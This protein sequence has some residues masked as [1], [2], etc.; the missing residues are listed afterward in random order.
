VSGN[1]L[2]DDA[3][4][5]RPPP[6]V[7]LRPKELTIAHV[8]VRNARQLQKK[9]V[10]GYLAHLATQPAN[11][12]QASHWRELYAQ[13]RDGPEMS[14]SR[15]RE[16][17]FNYGLPRDK[18]QPPDMVALV[19]DPVRID[20]EQRYAASAAPDALRLLMRFTESLLR[21]TKR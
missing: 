4:S 12:A 17:A 20:F 8:P 16:I 15:L 7:R 19:D 5:P 13:L 14:S 6:H 9:I 18:W 2:I 21:P 1:H 11:A 3:S 10:I